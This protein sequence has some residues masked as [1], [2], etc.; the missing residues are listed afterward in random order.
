MTVQPNVRLRDILKTKSYF[1]LLRDVAELQTPFSG[2]ETPRVI[3]NN[4]KVRQLEEPQ[5]LTVQ[6]QHPGRD[7]FPCEVT[8]W[9][10]QTARVSPKDSDTCIWEGD[11]EG[12]ELTGYIVSNLSDEED[13]VFV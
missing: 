9:K 3:K 12:E 6:L 11:D 13:D 10:V 1:V 5:T 8:A 7:E 2:G 4:I